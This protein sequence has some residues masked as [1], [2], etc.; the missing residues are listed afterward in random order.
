MIVLK[1]YKCECDVTSL[2]KKLIMVF[3]LYDVPAVAVIL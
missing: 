2:T 3:H 1:R